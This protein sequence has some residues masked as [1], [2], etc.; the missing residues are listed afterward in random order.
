VLAV[1]QDLNGSVLGERTVIL[2]NLIALWKIRVK[3][4][5]SRPLRFAIDDAVQSQTRFYC[6]SDGSLVQ[7]RERAGQA[8]TYRARI[9]VRGLT[10]T[11]GTGT[12]KLGARQELTVALETD[13][14]FVLRI[15]W[16]YDCSIITRF[17]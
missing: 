11:G 15:H 13:Y 3:V 8:Q 1:D 5:L 6:H 12:E 9:H 10:K 7:N 4:V 17:G 16:T 14:R 2:R